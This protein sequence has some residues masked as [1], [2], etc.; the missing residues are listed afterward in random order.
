MHPLDQLGGFGGGAA[1]PNGASARTFASLRVAERQAVGF[2]R[3]RPP[4]SLV[5]DLN[6]DMFSRTWWRGFGTLTAMVVALALT[7]PT[8][9]EPLPST[10]PDRIGE[11]EAE[12]FRALAISPAADG[13]RT[14]GR[15]AANGLV[16]P[17]AF[18]P[19]RPRVELFAAFSAGDSLD[20]L[21]VRSGATY[22]DAAEAARL[23]AS[24]GG[25]VAPGTSIAITLGQRGATGKRPLE[26]VRLRAGLDKIA[27]VS[28]GASG[29]EI[30]IQ[31]IAV[32]RT[33]VR[34]SG[35][36]GDSLYWTLRASGLSSEAAADFL[37]A[38]GGQI[39][40]GAD[41]TT[42]DK[43]D[44]IFANRRAA[45]G[46]SQPGPLLYASLE[47]PGAKPLRLMKWPIGG[48]LEW[49]DVDGVG[50]QVASFAWPVHA[51][52]TS[53]FGMR[54]HPI[55]H[56]ARMH[57]GIDF[58]ASA[59]TPIYAAAD[60]Q[61][62]RAGWAGGY[63]RQVRLAHFGGLATSYSHMSRIV[64]EPGSFVT[65]GQLIGYVGSSGLSTGP[66]LHYEVYR[67]GVAV[68]PMGVKF[69]SRSLLEGDRLAAFKARFAE[70]MKV[71]GKG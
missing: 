59:G 32:D 4:F 36:V 47:R 20:R 16:E 57:K 14:G 3:A 63:G 19:D 53:G 6:E 29:L 48:R 58:G 8:A 23:V 24:A 65:Q 69:A 66:H 33:P 7:A 61:V 2:G 46:E 49:M 35:R 64:A 41:V 40:V 43:F 55:L 9:L 71:G 54:Y 56:F 30:A 44:L 50:Q 68:N 38:I 1:V 34:I 25:K 21:L 60:G 45:T 28:A 17:L 67:N 22:A 26:K 37:K 12:Q 15:M 52:I 42:G 13:S 5:V 11:A 62:T 39:D 27:T 70:L 18:A 10:N 31:S 51:P